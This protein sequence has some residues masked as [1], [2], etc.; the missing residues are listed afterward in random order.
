MHDLRRFR[1][2][3][4][5]IRSHH[6]EDGV[7]ID[8]PDASQAPAVRL[9]IVQQLK[10]MRFNVAEREE[11]I[12]AIS[13]PLTNPFAWVPPCH[14]MVLVSC[15]PTIT[16]EAYD[17]LLQRW[18]VSLVRYRFAMKMKDTLSEIQQTVEQ[19]NP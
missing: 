17:R 18:M 11:L 5:R 14:M 19:A 15:G 10:R 7:Q 2:G 6:V 4:L 9:R 8:S 1:E 3:R 13:R 16:I 12:C